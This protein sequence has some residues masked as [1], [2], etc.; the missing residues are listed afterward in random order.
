[1]CGLFGTI[2]PQRYSKLMRSTAATALLDLGCSAQERGT[3]SAGIATFHS[4][5][6]TS[7]DTST[8][9]VRN[10]T[11]GRW[12]IVTALGSFDGQV[13]QQPRLRD[14]LRTAQTVLGHTRWATQGS[15]SLNNT[16]PMRV[17]DVLG[18][19]NGDVKV[20]PRA[21]RTGGTDSAWLF[22]QLERSTSDRATAAVLAGLR[23]RAALAW[24]RLSEPGYVFL[25]RASL[26][27]LAVAVDLE[28]ALWWASNPSWLRKVDRWSNL[29]LSEPIMLREGT[30]L[31]LRATSTAVEIVGRRSFTPTCRRLDEQL[32][33]L[34]V[35]RG[36]DAHDRTTDRAALTHRVI[37]LAG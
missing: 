17:G 35:W 3:D 13:P 4:R 26:S 8:D 14:N 11:D 31:T 12:R 1:M 36:F 10:R 9:T 20:W 25:A 29:R 23:G 16:S 37:D 19:H 30:L 15:C 21:R 5:R 32:A 7:P 6:L 28:G 24:A 34:A 27:P 18:T 22:E 2:R 33:N